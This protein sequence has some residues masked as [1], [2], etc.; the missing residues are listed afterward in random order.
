MG[1]YINIVQYNIINFANRNGFRTID[2]IISYL[3]DCL[4]ECQSDNKGTHGQYIYY[5]CQKVSI[6]LKEVSKRR[7]NDF[8]LFIY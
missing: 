6:K 1:E 7:L 8:E 5:K 4:I 3:T 2:R